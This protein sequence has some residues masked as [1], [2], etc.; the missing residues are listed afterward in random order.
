MTPTGPNS[1]EANEPADSVWIF[2]A[3]DAVRICS[4][5]TTI[6]PRS[7]EAGDA[8][9]RTAASRFA[10]PSHPASEI[11]R[12]APTRTTGLGDTS[13]QIEKVGCFLERVG[14]VRDDEAVDVGPLEPR[15]GAPRQPPHLLGRDVRS[16]QPRDVL[17]VD[18]GDVAKPWDVLEDLPAR[19]RGHGGAGARVERIDIVPPVKRIV[20]IA[21]SIMRQRPRRTCSAAKQHLAAAAR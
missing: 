17:E 7:R 19:Q 21:A 15:G 5:I 9:T 18:L 1:G 16:R 13:E 3:S 6:T 12:I 10:G 11:V 20:T 8:A 14:A 2:W 4:F